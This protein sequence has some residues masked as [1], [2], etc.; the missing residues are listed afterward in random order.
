MSEL[1]RYGLEWK[2]EKDFVCRPMADGYWTPWHIA[3][4]ELTHLKSEVERLRGRCSELE[5]V[6][7]KAKAA[8]RKHRWCGDCYPENGWP[9]VNEA[10]AC[11]QRLRAEADQMEAGTAGGGG[12]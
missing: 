10:L 9:E 1:Q 3:T 12:A 4:E 8:L 2:S 11:A 6:I 5:N 7:A